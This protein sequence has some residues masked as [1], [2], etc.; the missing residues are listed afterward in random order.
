LTRNPD[1]TLAA[2]EDEE[3]MAGHAAWN[4]AAPAAHHVA[5]AETARQR[6]K[7]RRAASIERDA[8]EQGAESLAGSMHGCEEGAGKGEV[9]QRGEHNKHDDNSSRWCGSQP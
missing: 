8:V 2:G 4:G 1:T 5:R 6:A 3:P 7:A 9:Y